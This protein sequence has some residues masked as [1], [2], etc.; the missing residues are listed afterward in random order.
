[1]SREKDCAGQKYFLGIDL[2]PMLGKS[3]G[4]RSDLYD[5][6]MILLR[7]RPV[8]K[9]LKIVS[10]ETGLPEGWLLSIISKPHISPSVHRIEHL[11]RY[12]S[13]KHSIFDRGTNDSR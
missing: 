9:T 1:M 4:Y 13:H 3:N 6:T 11:Y 10:E 2:P 5:R 12:L 8:T 7:N